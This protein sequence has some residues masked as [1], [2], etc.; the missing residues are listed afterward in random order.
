M[1]S[2]RWRAVLLGVVGLA[3]LALAA[4]LFVQP[5]VGIAARVVAVVRAAVG[6]DRSEWLLILVGV[7]AA[8]LALVLARVSGGRYPLTGVGSST[9]AHSP[10]SADESDSPPP[11][12]PDFES[13]RR[14]PPEVPARRTTVVTGADFDGR[15]QGAVEA[16]EP[17]PTESDD[18]AAVRTRLRS[19]AVEILCRGRGYDRDEA[20]RALAAGTWTEDPVAAAFLA[21]ASTSQ[22]LRRRVRRWVLP[23]AE[24][25]AR[26]ERTVAELER[27]FEDREVRFDVD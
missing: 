12:V 20:Q 16:A 18:L 22:P 5:E 4:V 8:L 24:R 6:P 25:R 11:V 13:L 2:V 14:R 19:L 10:A 15:V 23:S 26:I 27:A 1:R 17:T 3:A 21:D 9:A 7:V